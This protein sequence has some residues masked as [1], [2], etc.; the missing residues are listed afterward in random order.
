[1]FARNTAQVSDST[2][3]A[4]IFGMSSSQAYITVAMSEK[5]KDKDILPQAGQ[6]AV[7]SHVLP[8]ARTDL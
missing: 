1:M 2:V 3:P 6:A 8:L 4:G 5:T 7:S